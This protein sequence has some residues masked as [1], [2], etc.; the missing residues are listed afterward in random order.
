LKICLARSLP[1]LKTDQRPKG[2]SIAPNS[3]DILFVLERVKQPANPAVAPAAMPV[4]SVTPLVVSVSRPVVREINDYSDFTGQIQ[5]I[6]T[7]EIRARVNGYLEKVHFTGG[8]TVKKGDLLLEIDPRSF[9]ADLAKHEAE[10]QLSQVRLK[11]LSELKKSKPQSPEELRRIE[12]EQAE[13]EAALKV[14]Q[15][16]L[17]VSK[18]TLD[19]TKLTA[20]I[21]GKISGALVATGNLVTTD[22]TLLATVISP[23]PMCVVFDVDER[24]ALRLRRTMGKDNDKA[25]REWQFPVFCGLADEAGFPHRGKVESVDIRTDPAAGTVRWRAVLPN[26]QGILMPGLFARVR[27]VTSGPHKALLVPE[28]ALGS[29]QGQKFVYIVTDQNAVQY[30]RVK[31]G[32]VDNALRVVEEGLTTEDWVVVAG[33]QK[34]RPGVIVKPEKAAIP[35]PPSSFVP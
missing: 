18:R 26:P 13:A 34:L 3:S 19:L 31:V 1:S 17:N 2:F 23:D 8:T 30:R 35:V 25:D 12:G 16:G 15:E 9:Q 6:E 7:A 4:V 28:G 14:A 29:D 32:Q 21:G 24:E 20:P 27:L 33:L 5:P 11:R 22:K 10:V